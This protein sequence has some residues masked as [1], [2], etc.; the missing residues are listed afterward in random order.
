MR[1][2]MTY[3][4]SATWKV[5]VIYVDNHLVEFIRRVELLKKLKNS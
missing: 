4:V 3:I 1:L 2:L 5:K